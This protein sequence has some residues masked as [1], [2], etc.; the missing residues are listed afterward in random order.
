M[1]RHRLI[2]GFLLPF[3]G[4][5]TEQ[6]DQRFAILGQVNAIPR[7]PV[8]LVLTNTSEPFDVGGIAQFQPSLGD[9]YFRC[10][11]CIKRVKPRLVR[12]GSVF[13]DVFFKL[14][15]YD[16]MVTYRLPISKA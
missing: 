9:R 11:L 4:A 1:K 12:I 16:Q 13:P 6:N 5:A 14:D 7:P 3:L 8:D 10:G 2:D 15:L